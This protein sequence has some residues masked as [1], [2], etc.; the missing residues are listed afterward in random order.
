MSSP[1]LTV[2]KEILYFYIDSSFEKLQALN[3]R[4]QFQESYREIDSSELSKMMRN[5]NPRWRE[6]CIVGRDHI[7]IDSVS[8]DKNK[9]VNKT[10]VIN[11]PL[12]QPTVAAS[13][14]CRL[15]L[16]FWDG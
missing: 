1:V 5:P 9:I 16:K 15:I 3:E 4:C 13:S 10:G 8:L 6:L 11:D 2:L 7:W 12:S 14:A